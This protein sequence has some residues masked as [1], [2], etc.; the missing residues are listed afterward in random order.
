MIN[1]LPEPKKIEEKGGMSNRF[2]GIFI[3]GDQYEENLNELLELTKLRFWNYP[4]IEITSGKREEE[5]ALTLVPSLKGI[6]SER[7]GLF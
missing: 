1:I 4:E 3:N 2:T 6:A 7:Q 5:Y